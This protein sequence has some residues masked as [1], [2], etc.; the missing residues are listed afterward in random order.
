MTT[1]RQY[2]ITEMVKAKFKNGACLPLSYLSSRIAKQMSDRR[3]NERK[4]M[5][6]WVDINKDLTAKESSNGNCLDNIPEEHWSMFLEDNL[7]S[8]PTSTDRDSLS[9]RELNQTNGE[10]STMK[11]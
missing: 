9:L 1:K 11:P 5:R 8:A 3:N 6:A 7:S 10:G 4:L 2:Q